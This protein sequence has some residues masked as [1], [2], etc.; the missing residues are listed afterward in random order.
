M[1]KFLSHLII[2]GIAILGG[3][4]LWGAS[5]SVPV[6]PPPSLVPKLPPPNYAK[7]F[8]NGN[9]S[10]P[11]IAVVENAV[12]YRA[13]LSADA[14]KQRDLAAAQAK[15]ALTN[16][17]VIDASGLHANDFIVRV[18]LFGDEVPE[19]APVRTVAP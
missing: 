17:P 5:L 14:Q 15:S 6:V 3:L 7:Y 19:S 4:P 13:I 10:L 2:F 9:M 12:G 11:P 18:I 16:A 1:A 8:P